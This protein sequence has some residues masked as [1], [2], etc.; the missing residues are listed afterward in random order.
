MLLEL[1]SGISDKQLNALNGEI[2]QDLVKKNKYDKFGDGT[3]L[4]IDVF[5]RM[6]N[7]VFN[8]AWSWE[9]VSTTDKE[10]E[11]G[12][13]AFVLVKGRLTVPG[14]GVKEGFGIGKFD[15]KDNSTAYSAAASFAFK[16]CCRMVGVGASILDEDFEE[17]LLEADVPASAPANKAASNSKPAPAKEKDIEEP[18]QKADAPKAA[19]N[20]W[21]ETTVK[22]VNQ[23]KATYKIDTTEQMIVFAQIWNPKI[24]GKADLT[25]TLFLDLFDY[26]EENSEEFESFDP[27]EVA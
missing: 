17:P 1:M 10:D 15:K 3:Y 5:R 18:Q 25:P 22:K 19:A 12:K 13:I 23:L 6:M 7:T 8:H 11:S 24:K 20:A 21:P 27:S 9:I 4:S 2:N 16:N 26:V 14:I